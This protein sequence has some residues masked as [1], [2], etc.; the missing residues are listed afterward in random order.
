MPSER[1]NLY[2]AIGIIQATLSNSNEKTILDPGVRHDIA[3][4]TGNS[5]F[6]F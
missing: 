3:S 1:P 5:C 4:H 6:K 2:G